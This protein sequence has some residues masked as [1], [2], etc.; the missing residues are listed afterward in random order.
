M[1]KA[2]IAGAVSKYKQIL[3]FNL[4]NKDLI[5]DIQITYY[6]MPNNHPWCGGRINR[7]LELT[8]TIIETFNKYK[9]GMCLGFTNSA[10][11]NIADEEGNKLLAMI[12]G[13]NNPNK[14]H[15]VVLHSETLRRHI[16]KNYPDLKLT[17]SITAHPTSDQLNFEG[18]YKE[19]EAKYD[20]IVPKYSHLPQ[21]LELLQAGKLNPTKYEIL[22]NDNCDDKCQFYAEHFEQI[23]SMNRSI[24][25]PWEADWDK[26]FQ[27][28][29]K[30]MTKTTITKTAHCVQ[31]HL[32]ADYLQQFHDTGVTHFKISG[33]DLTDDLFLRQLK[34]H[35][36]EMQKIELRNNIL[37]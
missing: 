13:E 19:I 34:E 16:R 9:Q 32:K 21:V 24:K 18:Y 27:V 30:P 5:K 3:M 25:A 11:L 1:L 29:V 20:V 2:K 4:M 28:E 23:S 22:I 36:T 12:S 33:R 6:D 14:L 7:T 37:V 8:P 15:G 35:L 10:I 31:D 26:A 17:F